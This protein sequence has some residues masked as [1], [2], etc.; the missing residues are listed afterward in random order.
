MASLADVFRILNE[1]K[2]EGVIGEYAIGGAMA[3]LF[4]AE[5]TRT[6]DVDV[7]ARLP[8]ISVRSASSDGG[9]LTLTALYEWAR[10]RGFEPH[11]E[12][13]VIHSV[14]VQFLAA[15][16]GL[17]HEAVEQAQTL[18]Y[19]GVAV[20]V[21]APHHLIALYLRAGGARRRERV[22]MLREAGVVDLDA[23][24][25]VLERYGLE[26]AAEARP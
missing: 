17:E 21:I 16:D 13:L 12:H 24:H 7:F 10:A 15:D 19:E 18:D 8:Q 1:M 22:L 25:E 3:T 2:S 6:Y 20:R 26:P 5:A 23:L 9:F 14:P 11:D 4:Y